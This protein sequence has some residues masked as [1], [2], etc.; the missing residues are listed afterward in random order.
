MSDTDLGKQ[1]GVARISVANYRGKK[2]IPKF[3]TVL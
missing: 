3:G 1:I 2:G